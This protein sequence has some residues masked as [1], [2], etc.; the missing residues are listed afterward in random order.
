MGAMGLDRYLLRGGGVRRDPDLAVGADSELVTKYF[1][2]WMA[3]VV[4]W[5]REQGVS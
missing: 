1:R 5:H 4:G 3:G 2:R